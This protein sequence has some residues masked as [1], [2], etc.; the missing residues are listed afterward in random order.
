MRVKKK[1]RK[2]GKKTG[3]KKKTRRMSHAVGEY[4]WSSRRKSSLHGVSG[5]AK[6][7]WEMT[8]WHREEIGGCVQSL[9]CVA[10]SRLQ[11]C[12]C[13]H[14]VEMCYLLN[15]LERGKRRVMLQAHWSSVC[16]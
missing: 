12:W 13:V 8:A 11:A 1:R 4:A 9:A 16:A 2:K 7:K 5:E 15:W 10:G 14:Y 6:G 3:M